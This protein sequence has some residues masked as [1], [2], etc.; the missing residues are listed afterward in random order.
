MISN[1]LAQ[2]TKAAREL[3]EKAAVQEHADATAALRKKDSELLA[4]YAEQERLSEQ[5]AIL[6][7]KYGGVISAE[8]LDQA[9]RSSLRKH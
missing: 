6:K 8:E 4:A 7:L 2:V 1:S 3:F 9:V 5:L